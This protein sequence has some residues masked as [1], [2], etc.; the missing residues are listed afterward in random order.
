M[1]PDSYK[2]RHLQNTGCPGGEMVDAQASGACI[3]KDVEV[4]VFFRAPFFKEL[5]LLL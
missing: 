1:S 2:S 5:C 4:R 3:R